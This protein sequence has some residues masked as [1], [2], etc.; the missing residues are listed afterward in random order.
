MLVRS[1][2]VAA[3]VLLSGCSGT[4]EPKAGMCG[5]TVLCGFFD[6][7]RS[8]ESSPIFFAGAG[9]SPLYRL[10]I[11]EGSVIVQTIEADGNATSIGGEIRA[12]NCADLTFSEKIYIIGNTAAGHS[13]GFYYRVP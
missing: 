13:T 1:T 3:A 11:E 4:S 10:C 5:D 8:K 9:G 12:G 6:I 2:A 7:A